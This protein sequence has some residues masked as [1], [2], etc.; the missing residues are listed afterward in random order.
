MIVFLAISICFNSGD[1]AHTL[2]MLPPRFSDA[3]QLLSLVDSRNSDAL[4]GLWFH[5]NYI[6]SL[7]INSK[8]NKGDLCKLKW[9]VPRV[10]VA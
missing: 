10:L 4:A 5:S 7:R 3:A 9:L 6:N 2:P 8:V 1:T